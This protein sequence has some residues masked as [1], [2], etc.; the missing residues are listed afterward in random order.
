M[1]SDFSGDQYNVIARS[2]SAALGATATIEE[3]TATALAIV[4]NCDHAGIA[5][6][7]KGRKIE[8]VAPTDKTV[9]RADQ[10]QYDVNDGPCLQSIREQE[11]VY[12]DD[13]RVDTRWPR[14]A[15]E[16]TTEL[17]IRSILSLQ[18]F[19]GPDSMGSLNLYSQSPQAFGTV[20]RVSAL[21][22]A[23]HIA[24][25]MTAAKDKDNFE[26]ALTH[27]TVIGQA[28]GMLMQALQIT[29]AQ[30]FAALVRVSQSKNIKLH[31][32]A[33]DIVSRGI[34]AELFD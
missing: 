7:S 8:T 18:L 30:A 11:T 34:R 6:V 16:A 10:L 27:R 21:A 20:D 12:S 31:V 23:S 25:A 5:V 4:T 32:V 2:L 33:S 26:S 13:L 9:I 24:V 22:L 15:A 3:A 1:V 17:G 19:V 14:W 28:E 29:P